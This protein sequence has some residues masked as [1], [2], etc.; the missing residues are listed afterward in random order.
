MRTL[1]QQGRSVAWLA[2]KAGYSRGYVS[3]ILH[4]KVDF[5]EEFQRRAIDAL[6]TNAT[7]PVTYR[8]QVIHVPEDIY[9]RAGDLPLIVVE[10]AYE[11][12]WK[13]AWL[14]EHAQSTLAVASERAWAIASATSDLDAA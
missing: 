9:R 5:T 4:G 7:V 10:S 11:E 12:A 6:E 14:A 13:R 2:Q 3:D 1:R 8:G